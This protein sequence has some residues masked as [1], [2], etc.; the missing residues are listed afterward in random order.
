MERVP[1]MHGKVAQVRNDGSGLFARLPRR[2]EATRYHSIAVASL[3]STLIPNAWSEDDVIMGVRHV[4]APAHGVQ[5]HPES[6][7]SREGRMLLANF[8]EAVREH[9]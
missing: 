1:P 8:V 9:A 4:E 5:F 3:P 6:V 2:L 7:A